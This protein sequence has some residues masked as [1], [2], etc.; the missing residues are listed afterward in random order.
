MVEC[1]KTNENNL[2]KWETAFCE[3][4]HSASVGEMFRGIL[5]NLN[6]VNQAFSLQAALFKSMFSQ[7]GELLDEIGNSDGTEKELL[8]KKLDDLLSQRSMMVDQMESKLQQSCRIVKRS[9]PLANLY[10]L[11]TEKSISV[12]R[13]IDYEVEIL[14][15]NSFFKH[16]VQKNIILSEDL[17]H[18]KCHFVE[19]HTVLYVIILNA[20]DALKSSETPVLTVKTENL[21][22]QIQIT[23]ENSGGNITHNHNEEIY[24]PFYSTK[25]GHLGVGLYLADKCIKTIG[26][27]IS[28]ATSDGITS[29]VVSIP[30]EQ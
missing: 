8:I 25:K 3:Q 19:L 7:A 4:F 16:E 24:Q 28:Y 18:L 17:P 10:E 23:I 14:L 30:T 5:H 12:N 20:I 2:R 6:G 29:F 26:G 21:D 11:N 15:A 1:N 27:T 13:I 9:L 22:K